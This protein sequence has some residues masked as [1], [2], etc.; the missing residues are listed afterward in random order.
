MRITKADKSFAYTLTFVLLIEAQMLIWGF[1][2]PALGQS[3]STIQI[4]GCMLCVSAVII[5]L[6]TVLQR[7]C[8]VPVPES[9]KRIAS[10]LEGFVDLGMIML[11]GYFILKATNC[12]TVA[13]AVY[14]MTL[15]S[16]K[17]FSLF[18][19][20]E[21]LTETA[22]IRLRIILPECVAV[23]LTECT[24]IAAAFQ[25][26]MLRTC[27]VEALILYLLVCFE[28]SR[29]KIRSNT[30]IR[31]HQWGPEDII[32]CFTIYGFLFAIVFAAATFSIYGDQQNVE[33]IIRLY[34]MQI[35]LPFIATNM[36]YGGLTN[37]S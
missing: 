28:S 36:L 13:E 9:M 7:P 27:L 17:L 1:G 21:E 25:T 3:W 14:M 19:R 12:M 10:N 30:S 29:K 18:T 16:L 33:H 26:W 6:C 2:L 37:D 34:M 5:F 11:F 20:K 22:W 24:V 32:L 23:L 15:I 8:Y 4:S 31:R 35:D